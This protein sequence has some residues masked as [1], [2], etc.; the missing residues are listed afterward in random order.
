MTSAQRMLSGALPRIGAALLGPALAGAG[1]CAATEPALIAPTRLTS[2]YD[3]S[4]RD[5]I[6]AVVPPRNESGTTHPDPDAIGDALVAAAAEVEGITALPVNRTRR[7][8]RALGIETVASP[9]EA[10]QLASVLGADAVLVS[11]L[12]AWDPYDPP[13]VGLNASLFPAPGAPGGVGS[14][15][16]GVDDT[17]L[18][19]LRASEGNERS[20]FGGGTDAV[21]SVSRQFDARDHETVMA[22]RRYAEGRTDTDDPLGWR[23]HV[24]SSS[25]Y[26]AFAAHRAVG[27]LLDQEWLRLARSANASDR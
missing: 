13:S 26:T 24:K 1:G 4:N 5:V 20:I 25:L 10:N 19:Q 3:T 16:P 12:T 8:M 2:P 27:L 18:F 17:R 11:T 9:G 7:A 23:V 22:L 21:A 6:W 15:G 14:R